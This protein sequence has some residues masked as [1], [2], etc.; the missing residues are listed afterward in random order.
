MFDPPTSNSMLSGCLC[1]IKLLKISF[2]ILLSYKT[3]LTKWYLHDQGCKI[4]TPIQSEMSKFV[5]NAV[6][7]RIQIS[8]LQGRII[9]IRNIRF[10]DLETEHLFVYTEL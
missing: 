5:Q 2:L 9:M 8:I 7:I 4:K 10:I 1:P 3:N 6:I